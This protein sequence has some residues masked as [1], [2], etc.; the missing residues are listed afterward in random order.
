MA[1]SFRWSDINLK[2]AWEERLPRVRDRLMPGIWA[3]ANKRARVREPLTVKADVITEVT[4]GFKYT[5][6]VNKIM[7]SGVEYEPDRTQKTTYKDLL[8]M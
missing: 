1:S 7:L 4:N 5:Q 8:Q 3:P 6:H 2:V